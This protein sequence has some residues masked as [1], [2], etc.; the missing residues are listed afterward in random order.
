[1]LVQLLKPLN[2]SKQLPVKLTSSVAVTLM[3]ADGVTSLPQLLL[4]L[5]SPKMSASSPVVL[6]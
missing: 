5:N 6:L 1:M 2:S 3:T 4:L